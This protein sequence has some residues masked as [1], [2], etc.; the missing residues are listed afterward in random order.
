[1][2]S[3]GIDVG[4]T[5]TDLIALDAEGKILA[6]DKARTSRGDVSR[7]VIQLIA[8]NFQGKIDE[9]HLVVNG[10]TAGTNAILERT[11]PEIA[12]LTTRGFRD[13]LLMRRET[14]AELTNLQWDKPSP[15]VKRRNIFEIGERIDYNG[16]VFRKL[17]PD[18]V[19]AAIEKLKERKMHSI[20]VV[21][22]HSYA[23]PIHE[24]LVR[25]M[26]LQQMPGAEVT[27]S[28]DILPEWREFE[29]TYNTVLA[30]ALKPVLAAYI[31]DLNG[32]L[33]SIGFRGT[34]EIMQANAGVA[35]VENIRSNPI[36]TLYSGVAG[37]VIGGMM[38]S[39]PQRDGGN[40]ITFDMGGTSTDI[41]LVS[42]G[43]YTVTTEQE[44]EWEGFLKV[45]CIDIHSIG[46]G[47]GSIA[48]VDEAGW[49]HVGPQSAGAVPGPA[50]Y[51]TGGEA[52][53][54]TDANLVLGY[55]NPD[56]Y[57]GGRYRLSVERAAG[58]IEKLA[59]RLH[60]APL[61]CALG[62]KAI[63]DANMVNGIRHVSVEKG[64]DPREYTL[65][66]FGGAGPL[67]AAGLM[68]Q[69]GIKRA[70]VP[71]YPGNVSA[72]G[73]LGA[74]PRIDLMR[75]NYIK[76]DEAD[77][78]QLESR[79]RALEEEGLER[80]RAWE[81]RRTDLEIVRSMDMRYTGQTHEL[82]IDPIP[83]DLSKTG[84][85]AIAAL[86]HA[87]HREL[88][89]YANEYEPIAVV[90]LRV[91]V[92]GPK[93]SVHLRIG[94]SATAANGPAGKR[95]AAFKE[96][97]GIVQV[98]TEVFQ[99]ERL[100]PGFTRSGPAII[101]E[102]LSTTLIPPGFRVKVIRQGALEIAEKG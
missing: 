102:D 5:H 12:L 53:T 85:K 66:A 78:Q 45:P 40:I 62:I 88:Y 92:L 100:P 22:I 81:V 51:D 31:V 14:K 56:N 73:L 49:P 86:F 99:R 63:V 94:R 98:E 42:R 52:P 95:K 71:P 61:E 74:R 65:V 3:V 24:K 91:A 83:P 50:C 64:I 43:A 55:L 67:H 1:M 70:I 47:G 76:L 7:A 48:W 96:D 28:Y 26:I 27:I 57:I 21:F 6:V 29:R 89:S 44:L 80:T 58:A 16:Q 68:R 4:G 60:L 2:V 93:R 54:V 87:R 25:E 17:D 32:K 82:I 23:N 18:S 97:R 30:A 15:L 72:A 77:F 101:E 20:A 19:L 46:A 35:T 9:L 10:T 34:L 41:S 33:K 69:L 84:K 36:S 38:S 13:V 90:N 11:I 59:R 75:T 79:Y 8:D 39:D 37:G